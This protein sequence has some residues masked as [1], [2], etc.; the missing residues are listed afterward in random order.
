MAGFRRTPPPDDGAPEQANATLATIRTGFPPALRTR[1]RRGPV[2]SPGTLSRSHR[3]VRSPDPIARSATP[4]ETFAMH[5]RLLSSSLLVLMLCACD[6]KEPPA[7]PA[8]DAA[9]APTPAAAPEAP[10]SPAATPVDAAP[11]AAAAPLE[12]LLLPDDTLASAQARLGAANVVAREL[13]G[14]EGETF[15]GWVLYPDDAMRRIDVFLD[16]G[17]KHPASLR[18]DAEHSPWQRADGIR[19]GLTSTALQTMNGKPFEFLGFDW[20]Y[21]G[22]ITDWRE[23]KLAATNGGGG[24]VRLCPP[25]TTPEGYPSGDSPFGS[26]DPHLATSPAT[27]CEFSVGIGEDRD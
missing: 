23:G 19:I 12:T 3:P 14:A 20:D 5:A 4:N 25:E 27:V 16:E 26:D 15:P 6:G 17:G 8:A 21:G 2:R 13:D 10:P 22:A 1:H 24:P 18:I 11:N 9:P 7:A